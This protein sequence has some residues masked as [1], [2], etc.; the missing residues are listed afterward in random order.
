MLLSFQYTPIMAKKGATSKKSGRQVQ[1][2]GTPPNATPSPTL[3][4]SKPGGALA[5]DVNVD[6]AQPPPKD[7]VASPPA[8]T[9]LNEMVVP[10]CEDV[11]AAAKA[12]VSPSETPTRQQPEAT[13]PTTEAPKLPTAVQDE[14]NATS[15]GGMEVAAAMEEFL[16]Q[17]GWDGNANAAAYLREL[18]AM[19]T[20]DESPLEICRGKLSALLEANN[21]NKA[22]FTPHKFETQQHGP[23]ASQQDF[24]MFQQTR[25]AS[26]APNAAAVAN[27]GMCTSVLL[28]SANLLVSSYPCYCFYFTL[29]RMMAVAKCQPSHCHQL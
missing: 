4:G 23:G 20:S 21:K 9:L 19:T 6:E 24:W 12:T 26:E 17:F 3:H 7:K 14:N 5:V 8:L 22:A 13:L 29:K 11:A 27:N 18:T 1:E 10:T 25:R 16:Q 15:T 2:D 28:T